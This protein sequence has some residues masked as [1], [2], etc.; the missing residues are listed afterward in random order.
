[1]PL[2]CLGCK[3]VTWPA[4]S[5]QEKGIYIKI[6][7]F[8][9]WNWDW[10]KNSRPPSHMSNWPRHSPLSH[11]LLSAPWPAPFCSHCWGIRSQALVCILEDPLCW[12]SPSWAELPP[13]W[14]RLG[15]WF[16]VLPAW[17]VSTL[18]SDVLA[19]TQDALVHTEA[20]GG[21]GADSWAGF[22]CI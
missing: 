11:P 5:L 19:S 10:D 20:R 17:Q 6:I 1:M 2:C 22:I 3:E 14:T 12:L 21:C 8:G 18:C 13:S 9:I 7:T 16:L 15:S 4:F